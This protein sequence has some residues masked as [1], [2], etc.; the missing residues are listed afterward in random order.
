MV[1]KDKDKKEII[2]LEAG[3]FEEKMETVFDC[4]D[5]ISMF[6]A[7]K[8][9]KAAYSKMCAQVLAFYNGS[10]WEYFKEKVKNFTLTPD[11]NYIE[12]VVSAY[13]NSVYSGL[14]I[15]EL[16]PLDLSNVEHADKLNAFIESEFHRMGMKEKFVTWGENVTL[17]NMQPVLTYFNSE[18]SKFEFET[19]HPESIFLDPSVSEYENGGA[20]FISK[21]VNIYSLLK[22]SRFSSK[23][24]SYIEKNRDSVFEATEISS[25][26]FSLDRFTTTGNKTVSMIQYYM[27]NKDGLYEGFVI[28]RDEIIYEKKIQPSIYPITILYQ[29]KPNG[30]PYGIPLIYKI[31]HS[32]ITL[33]LLDSMDATQPYLAQNRPRF[34]NLQSRIIPRSFID[35]GNTPDA[36]FPLWGDP[37]KAVHYQDVQF[38]PDTFQIKQRLEYGI[39]NITGVD[40][41]YK[42]RQTNSITTTGGVEAQQAR[43]VMLT[44]NSIIVM[45]ESFIEKIAKKLIILNSEHKVFAKVRRNNFVHEQ[46]ELVFADIKAKD[47]MFTIEA[48]PYLPMTKQTLFEAL[49]RLYEM[50]GQ[51]QF[52]VPLIQEED[53]L[54]ELPVSATKKLM[55]YQRISSQKQADAALKKRE[56]LM[57]FAA[58]FQELQGAGLP[59]DQAAE[60]ALK[61]MDEEEK[62][63]QQDPTLGMNPATMGP[64]G[65]KP[66][67]F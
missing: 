2:E 44:D 21:E 43:V 23:V 18:I 25:T 11:T 28:N 38:I 19:I 14:F 52:Q 37:T 66:K 54:A 24:R 30:N 4:K 61:I 29:R 60:E 27:K 31:L 13:V 41:A 32:Y 10:F 56:T 5:V 51:Y 40:P 67:M 59:D 47:I 62:M 46:A 6:D 39:F 3:S 50:Q 16:S 58:L 22:D 12:Y 7:Y 63:K 17:F 49:I 48:K 42:G 20:I 8:A 65:G 57:T 45:L 34:F 26:G 35:Y 9:G 1:K 53:L 33:N 15:P 36:T 55:M 64:S